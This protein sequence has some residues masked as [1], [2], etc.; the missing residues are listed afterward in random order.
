MVWYVIILNLIN[1][2]LSSCCIYKPID[3]YAKLAIDGVLRYTSHVQSS[4]TSKHN[5]NTNQLMHNDDHRMS[6]TM[7]LVTCNVVQ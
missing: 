3:K 4:N 2:H 1:E 7:M 6:K 5:D